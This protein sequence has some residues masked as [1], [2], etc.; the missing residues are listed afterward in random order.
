M[1]S[2]RDLLIRA[3][4]AGMVFGRRPTPALAKAS[5]PGTK[6]S[7][8]VPAGA[9]DCHTH[10]FGDPSRFS[11][12]PTRVYT[13]E[14]ASVEE[15]Q[16]LHRALHMDR[17][18]IVQPSVYATDN[19]CT[20]DAVKRLGS[21]ARAIVVIDEK[22]PDSALDEMH[23]AGAR[24]IRLNLETAGLTDPVVS[25]QRLQTAAE[26]IRGR[27]WHIQINT[28]LSVIQALRDRITAMPVTIVFDHF[29]AAQASLGTGQPGFEAL[30]DLVRSGK[31]YVK[32]SGAYRSSTLGPDYADAAP[33]AQALIAANPRRILWGTD[34]PHPDSSRVPGRK[35]TDVAPLLQVDDGRLLNQLPI[36]APDAAQRKVIL[37]ENPAEL[38]G[39]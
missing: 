39:F 30:S 32:I 27:G 24:G 9:C 25:G 3:A 28:R 13:P 15:M 20:L 29:G 10:V 21:R 22:T 37:M 36:W 34:W 38:Y 6:I 31:V 11:F 4:A 26:R 2:R 1:L 12:A 18:V 35:N 17:V 33:L 14:P 16:A 7:F 5:Q 8:D 23:R 19:A